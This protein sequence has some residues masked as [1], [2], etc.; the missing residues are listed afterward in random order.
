[1]RRR[2]LLCDR[3]LGGSGQGAVKR[4]PADPEVEDLALTLIGG[5]ALYPAAVPVVEIVRARAAAQG[6]G[7]GERAVEPI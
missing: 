2:R 3:I 5:G 4:A 7:V 6:T 1:V